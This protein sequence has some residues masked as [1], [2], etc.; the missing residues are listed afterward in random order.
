MGNDTSKIMQTALKNPEYRRSLTA[1]C[2]KADQEWKAGGGPERMERA[3]QA[4]VDAN[5]KRPIYH[6]TEVHNHYRY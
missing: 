3:Y 5:N 1:S 6:V 4:Q 2:V